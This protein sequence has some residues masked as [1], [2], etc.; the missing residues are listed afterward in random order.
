V[1]ILH[2]QA[3]DRAL[4]HHPVDGRLVVLDGQIDVAVGVVGDLGKLPAQA[5]IAIGLLQG[6]LEGEGQFRD[7]IGL[8]VAVFGDGIVQTHDASIDDPARR[9][10]R[11]VTR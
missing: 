1:V 6:A 11:I 4:P 5:D 2:L 10:A 8:G 3:A 7:R 9:F